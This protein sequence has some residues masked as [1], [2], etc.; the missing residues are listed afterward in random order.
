M[1]TT[2]YTSCESPHY[3][4]LAFPRDYTPGSSKLA[5]WGFMTNSPIAF[6]L[7]SVKLLDRF[8]STYSSATLA[9]PSPRRDLYIRLEILYYTPL[10]RD[11]MCLS[12]TRLPVHLRLILRCPGSP[13]LTSQLQ[14]LINKIAGPLPSRKCDRSIRQLAWSSENVRIPTYLPVV[15]RFWYNPPCPDAH[16]ARPL[17]QDIVDE[18]RGISSIGKP[19]A[20][21]YFGSRVLPPK[22]NFYS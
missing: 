22:L 8:S 2:V 18:S 13:L 5:D 17:L 6:P 7:G 10:F 19:A 16:I 3:H 15:G 11:W 9:F 20:F 12:L 14:R 1:N 21:S 4:A